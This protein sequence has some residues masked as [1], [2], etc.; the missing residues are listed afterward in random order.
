MIY[1]Y[2]S[3]CK[4]HH[5]SPYTCTYLNSIIYYYV[6]ADS[7]STITLKY[8]TLHLNVYKF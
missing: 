2:V 1:A 6:Q 8:I 7:P 3:V 5:L 4:V